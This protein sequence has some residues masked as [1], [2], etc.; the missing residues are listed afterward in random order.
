MHEETLIDAALA[1][2][3]AAFGQLVRTHQDRLFTTMVYVTGSSEDAK[4]VVQE[5]FLR[6]YTGLESFRR[7]SAFYT[8]LY[9]IAFRAAISLH[10]KKKPMAS[11]ERAHEMIGEDP[12]ATEDT[13]PDCQALSNERVEMVQTAITQ[14]EDEYRSV[15][16]LREIDGRSYDEIADVLDIPIGTVRSRLHRGRLQLRD[17]LKKIMV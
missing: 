5:A 14:L 11:I 13:Q 16:V 4:D 12:V 10:R 8:W 2:D 17:R 6:A 1:G 9:R 7:D 15:I 3:R